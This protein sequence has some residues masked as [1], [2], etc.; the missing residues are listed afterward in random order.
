[1]KKKILSLIGRRWFRIGISILL[2]LYVF[3]VII[4]SFLFPF[5]CYINQNKVSCMLLSDAVMNELYD[6]RN[7]AFTFELRNGVKEQ[8]LFSDLGIYQLGDL[9]ESVKLPNR[10][11]W[12]LSFFR[13]TV[14]HTDERYDWDVDTLL[15]SLK[16]LTFLSEDYDIKPTQA[17]VVKNKDGFAV[18][19]AFAGTSVDLARL[20]DQVCQALSSGKTSVDL[21]SEDCYVKLDDPIKHEDLMFICEDK[22]VYGNTIKLNMGCGIEEV[23]PPSVLSGCIYRGDDDQY[24]LNYDLFSDYICQLKAKYDTVGH[25]RMFQTS[26]GDTIKL[27]ASEQ[28]TFYG[29]DLNVDQTIAD[30]CEVLLSGKSGTINVIYYHK[31]FSHDQNNDFGDSYIELSIKKQH[32]WLY[33]DD[34]LV[35]DTDVTTGKDEPI[36]R[37]PTGLFCTMD[38]NTEYQMHG[39]YGTAF[40]HYFI[41]VTP[42]GVGI[43]DASWR[44]EYGGDHYIK[45]GSHGCINTPFDAVQKIFY[46]LQEY[47]QSIPVVIY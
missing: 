24:Y 26:D 27:S 3:G 45:D 2:F 36:T 10:F 42:E 7:Q 34:K 4:F 46:R 40:S 30:I 22:H 38:L 14:Y 37:T 43:H 33:L 44:S 28:D 21:E 1:M 47:G 6:T 5:R 8:V 35:I 20:F 31:G 16:N 23:I 12:P 11:L 15:A 25:D 19:P 32:M 9:D 29:W 39:W 13:D 17:R 18:V 41:R